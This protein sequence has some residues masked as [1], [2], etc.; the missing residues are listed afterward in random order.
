VN[1]EAAPPPRLLTR[2]EVAAMFRVEP[3]T[4]TRWAAA[5]RIQSVKTPGGHVRFR[6]DEVRA[7]VQGAASDVD[8]AQ[9]RPGDP[10]NRLHTTRA[11]HTTGDEDDAMGGQL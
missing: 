3:K 5:G 10:A 8:T 4:V 2:D 7:L 9:A 11:V 1:A 6:E